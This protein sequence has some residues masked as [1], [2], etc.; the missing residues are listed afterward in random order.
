M[1]NFEVISKITGVMT[2]VIWVVLLKQ[3]VDLTCFPHLDSLVSGS[4][5]VEAVCAPGN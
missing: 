3:A 2:D 1:V 5:T 4:S